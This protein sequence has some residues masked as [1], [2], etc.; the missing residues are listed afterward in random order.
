MLDNGVLSKKFSLTCVCEKKV[1][2]LHYQNENTMN[3]KERQERQS[4]ENA[5]RVMNETFAMC[6]I[7]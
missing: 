2:P 4:A 6:G 5:E 3:E 1:V 7:W